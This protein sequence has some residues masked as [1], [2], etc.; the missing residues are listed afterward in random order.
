MIADIFIL[1]KNSWHAKLMHWI[2]NY[3]YW[4]FRNMCPYFW[5]TVFNC[6]FIIPIAIVKITQKVCISLAGVIDDWQADYRARCEYKEEQAR[7]QFVK[8]LEQLQD[9]TDFSSVPKDKLELLKKARD[10]NNRMDDRFHDPRAIAFR[11]INYDLRRKFEGWLDDFDDLLWNQEHEKRKIKKE[12]D[13]KRKEKINAL[14][15]PVKQNSAK[16][17]SQLTILVKFVLKLTAG[18]ILV[19]IG[20][21]IYLGVQFAANWNWPKIGLYAIASILAA[22]IIILAGIIIFLICRWIVIFIAYLVCRYGPYC[23]PCERRR[24]K[25]Y[26]GFITFLDY[27]LVLFYPFVVLWNILKAL[28]SGLKL[29]WQVIV[30]LKQNNCPGIEWKD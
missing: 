23:I 7:R 13:R 6:V 29:L 1:K 3:H 11:S 20:Y 30:A 17:I 21:L 28:W 5:L 25:L 24:T 19:G 22:A 12:E 26:N 4:E 16:A 27:V 10:N 8:E 15:T 18:A 9:Y 2:W 14:L